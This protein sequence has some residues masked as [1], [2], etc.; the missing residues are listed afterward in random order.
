MVPGMSEDTNPLTEYL[1]DH[2]RMIGTLFMILLLVVQAG[3]VAANGAST[4]F[5]P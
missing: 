5:G 4:N 1:A 3:T 2:P